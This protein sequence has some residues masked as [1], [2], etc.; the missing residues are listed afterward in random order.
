MFKRDLPG[1]G[2]VPPPSVPARSSTPTSIRSSI[3]S[4]SL[5]TLDE[6]NKRFIDAQENTYKTFE[7]SRRQH[8]V[9]FLEAITTRD[10]GADRRDKEFFQLLVQ[11]KA[12]FFANR[13]DRND[14]F[15]VSE[16][17]RD[18]VFNVQEGTRHASFEIAQTRRD[19][20]VKQIRDQ[21]GQLGGLLTQRRE[22]LFSQGR[23][24]R[25]RACDDVEALFVL[26]DTL[27]KVEDAKFFEYQAARDE[28]VTSLASSYA[29]Q[30]HYVDPLDVNVYAKDYLYPDLSLT[31]VGK[32]SLPT[33]QSVGAPP[34]V[35][36]SPPTARTAAA[37]LPS[38]P[39]ITLPLQPL[40]PPYTPAVAPEVDTSFAQSP[41][42]RSSAQS[43][44]ALAKEYV[45]KYDDIFQEQERNRQDAFMADLKLYDAGFDQTEQDI[46]Q[47]IAS[48]PALLQ[49]I[50]QTLRTIYANDQE[51]QG[52]VTAQ[53]TLCHNSKNTHRQTLFSESV[54]T[55]TVCF[56]QDQVSVLRQF[57]F[58]DD[59]EWSHLAMLQEGVQSLFQ[60]FEDSLRAL[61]SKHAQIFEAAMREYSKL[62]G[63]E[64]FETSAGL[65]RPEYQSYESAPY[66]L[67]N[68]VLD[69]RYKTQLLSDSL[70][71]GMAPET[72]FDIKT[73]FRPMF[74]AKLPTPDSRL[75]SS[76]SFRLALLQMLQDQQTAFTKAQ[77]KR[78]K[79]FDESLQTKKGLMTIQDLED[80]RQFKKAQK[81][82]REAADA[83]EL[84]FAQSFS[85]QQS[86]RERQFFELEKGREQ[87]FADMAA[88]QQQTFIETLATF[89]DAFYKL[90]EALEKKA[91]EHEGIRLKNMLRWGHVKK[92]EVKRSVEVWQRKFVDAEEA[93]RK[94]FSL[95]LQHVGG[96]DY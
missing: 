58:I 84:E 27:M 71:S 5:P 92:Q 44:D 73:L 68:Q 39:S 15:D 13:K 80:D 65:E 43:L 16:E 62:F 41:P 75:Q 49:K 67:A 55:F 77:N 10:D 69:N 9:T 59:G 91:Y 78:Q 12:A 37:P 35:T 11:I 82:Y 88:Q 3:Q 1:T 24:K 94:R 89:E 21:H 70:S 14:T 86:E 40:L 61:A 20:T 95:L 60:E 42:R 18:T 57:T 46:K 96:S 74:S 23:T 28:R 36:L 83:W 22:V 2:V 63:F 79:E 85:G 72:S 34:P 81:V 45:S 19:C 53:K 31:Q 56:N 47:A 90:V 48:R 52:Q 8:R 26:F 50:S 87:Q 32:T 29:R 7:Q 76:D 30:G 25:Q 93:R 54:E 6:I 64:S 4:D 17:K 66:V 51:R 38:P 33:Y